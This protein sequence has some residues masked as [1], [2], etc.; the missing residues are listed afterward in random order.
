MA[1]PLR[2]QL[3]GLTYHI[4]S[5]GNGRMIIY[6]D[7]CDREKFLELLAE[8]VELFR[9]A[10]PAFCMMGNHYHLV[11]TTTD[12]NLSKAI[13]ALN[14]RYGQWWNRR[15]DRVGHVFQGRFGAKVVQQDPYLLTVCK[16]VVE[17]PVRRNLVESPDQWRWS[18]YRATAGLEPVPSFLRPEILW[19]VLG[20]GDLQA[21]T[22]RYR[23]FIRKPSDDAG[24]LLRLP[25]I[26]DPAFVERF[27]E[28]R[29]RASREVPRR[30]R[31]VRPALDTMFAGALT[32]AERNASAER[33]HT[34]G[35]PIAT[36]ARYLGLHPSTVSKM[37]APVSQG[38]A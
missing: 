33:A 12:A 26:G 17:N 6:L 30:E 35:Y 9:L 18:S 32:R 20:D 24:K 37:I 29:Q 2:I 13:H 21:R 31:Q 38:Q 36:I 10:C 28:F 11:I 16:Y 25:V 7:D 3:P 8:V 34:V 22:A 5:R 23:D 19:E 27:E 14:G 4:H 15:H 1:R